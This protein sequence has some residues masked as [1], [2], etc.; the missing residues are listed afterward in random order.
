MKDRIRK[1]MESQQMSQQEFADFIHISPAS[2]S[3]IFTGRTRPTL[4]IVEAIKNSL[5][6]IST[7][8]LL[9]GRGDMFIGN[10]ANRDEASQNAAS[11]ADNINNVADTEPILDFGD[12]PVVPSTPQAGGGAVARNSASAYGRQPLAGNPKAEVDALQTV[13]KNIDIPRRTIT[14]IRIFYSDQTW[15]TFVPKK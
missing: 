6:D 4:A 1:V 2:L 10:G 8:W 5:P 12:A 9:F 15:E 13:V 7:D 11:E 3:S 14:E